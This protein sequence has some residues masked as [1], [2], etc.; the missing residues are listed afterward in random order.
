MRVIDLE[1]WPRREHF[2]LYSGFRFPHV[3][4]CVRVDIT[5]LWACRGH[6]GASP[7]IALV[8]AVTKAA[9]RVPELRQRI[10]GEQIVEHDVIHPLVTVLG[11]DD[12]FGVIPL[13]YN[14]YFATFA[15]EAAERMAEAKESASLD[16]FPH[17][18]DVPARDDLLSISLLPW[19]AF[20]GFAITRQSETDS[21]P[22]VAIGKAQEVGER[23]LLPFYVN[24]HHALS[25]GLHA[26]RLVKHLQEEA[27]ELA[28]TFQ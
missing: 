16:E 23:Y 7:T 17:D 8:Y 28:V 15:A 19:L 5:E 24:F 20:T 9:N 27:Q 10:R 12:L 4:I 11:D 25:D 13:V 26:A 22:L 6:T 1:T 14:D 2:R 21:V 18:K 3:N